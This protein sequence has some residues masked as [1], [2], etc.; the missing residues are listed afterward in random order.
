MA[1]AATAASSG[2]LSAREA[3][4]IGRAAY[5]SLRSFSRPSRV[6]MQELHRVLAA[7]HITS[8]QVS[9][10]MLRCQCLGLKFDVEVAPLDR[11]GSIHEVRSRRTAG[12]PWQ[13]KDVCRRLLT[14]LRIV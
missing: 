2:P 12:E 3:R 13:Y 9:A 5:D 10:L 4:D 1:T 6:I 8:K 14:E 7:Q 11:L